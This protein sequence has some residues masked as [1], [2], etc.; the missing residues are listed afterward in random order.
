MKEQGLVQ[1]RTSE[2]WS[3]KECVMFLLEHTLKDKAYIIYRGCRIK[4]EDINSIE[5]ALMLWKEYEKSSYSEKSI[6]KRRKEII[7][8]SH[9]KEP[10][11]N[12]SIYTDINPRFDLRN[13]KG[14]TM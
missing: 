2:C 10:L 4:G 14:R 13:L 3:F 8:E 5:D 1:L 7:E 9:G 12:Y 11:D 6:K